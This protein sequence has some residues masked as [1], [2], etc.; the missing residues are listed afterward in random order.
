MFI[1]AGLQAIKSWEFRPALRDGNP[2]R[3][4]VYVSIDS[5]DVGLPLR[6]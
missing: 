4:R 1:T 5:L 2:V 6:R 3:Y